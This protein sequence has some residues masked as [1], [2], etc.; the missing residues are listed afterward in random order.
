[1][2]K[3]AALLV[4]AERLKDPPNLAIPFNNLFI[5]ITG[6]LNIQQIQISQF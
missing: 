3:V 6:K 1:V 4:N 5:T 2:G